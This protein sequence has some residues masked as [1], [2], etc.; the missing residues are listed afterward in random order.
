MLGSKEFSQNESQ[1]FERNRGRYY[2]E[3][4]EITD[5]V[6]TSNQPPF[7]GATWTWSLAIRVNYRLG[8]GKGYELAVTHGGDAEFDIDGNLSDWGRTGWKLDRFAKDWG[9]LFGTQ[10]IP[11]LNNNAPH[12]PE[13]FIGYLKGLKGAMLRYVKGL[14]EHGDPLY[15]IYE[16][17][18]G[19]TSFNRQGNSVSNDFETVKKA[20][21]ASF[22]SSV[23]RGF[24]KNYDPTCLQ[25]APVVVPVQTQ[26]MQAAPS[27]INDDL[28]F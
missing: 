21:I 3:P 22:E 17:T 11:M 23:E 28:P 26:T 20:L 24:P 13:E 1:P 27:S 25:D 18:R 19:L 10:S 15:G 12:I 4:C 16:V 7:P 2:V 14:D 6:E 8:S 5:A 9:L